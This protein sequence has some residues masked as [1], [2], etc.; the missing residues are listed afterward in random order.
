MPFLDAAGFDA[1]EGFQQ[2]LRAERVNDRKGAYA[3]AA[4]RSD[5]KASTLPERGMHVEVDGLK[6]DGFRLDLLLLVSSR[7]LLAAF[8]RAGSPD[9]GRSKRRVP[10]SVPQR[11]AERAREIGADGVGHAGAPSRGSAASAYSNSLSTVMMAASLSSSFSNAS[12]SPGTLPSSVGGWNNSCGGGP[13]MHSRWLVRGQNLPPS[14]ALLCLLPLGADMV[15]EKS[16]LAKPRHSAL[17]GA[18]VVA[19]LVGPCPSA[20]PEPAGPNPAPGASRQC[21]RF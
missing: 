11:N 9:V 3:S 7:H 6:E 4:R 12:P 17:G 20:T 1:D 18:Y 21:S 5:A 13:R 15:R 8:Q 14:P 19:N 2:K 16:P 10:E